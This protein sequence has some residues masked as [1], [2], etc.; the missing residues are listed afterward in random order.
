M[1]T[2]SQGIKT[3]LH[4]SLNVFCISLKLRRHLAELWRYRIWYFINISC[5]PA[6]RQQPRIPAM[7]N[8]KSAKANGHSFKFRKKALSQFNIVVFKTLASSND[9]AGNL[10]QHWGLS[11]QA[12]RKYEH[13]IKLEDSERWQAMKNIRPRLE[14]ERDSSL[15]GWFCPEDICWSWWGS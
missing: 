2:D 8:L 5:Y 9:E 1:R 12:T 11:L 4:E 6:L 14:R 7:V 13:K 15:N 10:D 3:D